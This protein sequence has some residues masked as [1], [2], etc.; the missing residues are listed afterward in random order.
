MN[1]TS[2]TPVKRSNRRVTAIEIS[3]RQLS[4]A[5][6]SLFSFQSISRSQQ[7][8]VNAISCNTL[9]VSA[10]AK[11]AI[12][13]FAVSHTYQVFLF[14]IPFFITAHAFVVMVRFDKLL[15]IF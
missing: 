9:V 6:C 7:Q 1:K 3:I 10:F 11:V 5:K 12:G 4:F 14:F 2:V 15:S 13:T 8:H